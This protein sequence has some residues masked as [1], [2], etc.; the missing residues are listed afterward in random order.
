M[1]VLLILSL[2]C[3]CLAAQKMPAAGDPERIVV[4]YPIADAVERA[5]QHAGKVLRGDTAT[6]EA[7]H[8]ECRQRIRNAICRFVTPPLGDGDHVVDLGPDRLV[9][10]VRQ[11]QAAWIDDFF[12]R[13][14]GADHA[15]RLDG[16]FERITLPVA[17]LAEIVK[18]P[19]LGDHV[20]L[21]LGAEQ[22]K[23]LRTGKR[24]HGGPL[25]WRFPHSTWMIFGQGMPCVSDWRPV[26][27]RGPQED[28]VAPVLGKV[29][30]GVEFEVQYVP[31]P[32]ERIGFAITGEWNVVDWKTPPRNKR[33]GDRDYAIDEPAVK[34]AKFDAAI[35]MD[36]PAPFA[37][38]RRMGDDVALLVFVPGK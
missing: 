14:A 36:R 27:L 7:M 37:F 29:F 26:P 30:D 15:A 17:R 13:L 38:G 28:L 2:L 20:E 32:G 19:E 31:L 5:M 35:A 25:S 1:R 24:D 3:P 33:I 12:R 16:T 10:L 8:A 18:Q 22:L 11:Q 21:V 4:V 23:A 6:P 34:S 9:A